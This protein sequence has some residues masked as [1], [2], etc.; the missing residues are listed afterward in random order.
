[1]GLCQSAEEKYRRKQHEAI[2]KQLLESG[3]HFK[4]T[5]KLLLLGM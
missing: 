3:R 4:F 2:E 5:Q 1:M